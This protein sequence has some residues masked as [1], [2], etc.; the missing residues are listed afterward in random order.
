MLSHRRDTEEL[1]LTISS[2]FFQAGRK[3]FCF[4]DRLG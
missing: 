4:F 2:Y 1:E 3:T